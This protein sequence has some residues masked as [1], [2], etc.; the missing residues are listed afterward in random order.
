ML[1]T[2]SDNGDNA[3][4]PYH[5]EDVF[6]VTNPKMPNAVREHRVTAAAP[7]CT[8][9]RKNIPRAS[10]GNRCDGNNSAHG[11]ENSSSREGAKDSSTCREEVVEAAGEEEY[12]DELIV[13]NPIH[14]VGELR[15]LAQDLRTWKQHIDMVVDRSVKRVSNG[16][17]DKPSNKCT[18][19]EEENEDMSQRRHA[20]HIE[21][22][23]SED[24]NS[25]VFSGSHSPSSVIEDGN[26]AHIGNCCDE[27]S[28]SDDGTSIKFQ[29]VQVETAS[30]GD[31]ISHEGGVEVISANSEMEM[32]EKEILLQHEERNMA[33]EQGSVVTSTQDHPE[34]LE[35]ANTRNPTA[36]V[37]SRD[38]V[39]KAQESE[40]IDKEQQVSDA[41]DTS[42]IAGSH[43]SGSTCVS[44]LEVD[45]STNTCQ[46]G[47][48]S[49]S[50]REREQ[51]E[52][53]TMAE[54]HEETDVSDTI[55]AQNLQDIPHS[56]ELEQ[57]QQVDEEN[58]PE[59]NLPLGND[60]CQIDMT[61]GTDWAEDELHL[62]STSEDMDHVQS[63]CNEE[64]VIGKGCTIGSMADT[65]SRSEPSSNCSQRSGQVI[66]ETYNDIQENEVEGIRLESAS[67]DSTNLEEKRASYLHVAEMI[68]IEHTIEQH[69]GIST[70]ETTLNVEIQDPL[71]QTEVILTDS[72]EEED[73]IDQT[74]SVAHDEITNCS[75]IGH[76]KYLD[77]PRE[78]QQFHCENHSKPMEDLHFV[79]D[80]NRDI[81]LQTTKRIQLTEMDD[82]QNHAQDGCYGMCV[83]DYST[84]V[85][86]AAIS[87]E[88]EEA[89]TIIQTNVLKDISCITDALEMQES[90][91]QENEVECTI[92]P[93][94]THIEEK[95]SRCDMVNQKECNLSQ[96]AA[97]ED[98]ADGSIQSASTVQCDQNSIDDISLQIVKQN[99]F[100]EFE[101]QEHIHS[102]ISLGSI[103]D[104]NQH[105]SHS[106][107]EMQCETDIPNSDSEPEIVSTEKNEEERQNI[108]E[109][110]EAVNSDLQQS[111]NVS[112]CAALEVLEVDPITT[113]TV[114]QD[115]NDLEIPES[116]IPQDPEDTLIDQ[117]TITSAF[118]GITIATAGSLSIPQ[119]Q[120]RDLIAKHGGKWVK[121]ASRVC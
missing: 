13:F 4:D 1:N 87:E 90:E 52:D 11:I 121:N 56:N 110:L 21:F 96:I 116:H 3:E 70:I 27:L 85:Q 60:Q 84:S 77:I 26:S 118:Q 120:I 40:T 89:S 111:S 61:D 12:K 101:S 25:P 15:E 62:S 58:R 80:V 47:I 42:F 72:H 100:I 99:S 8:N 32:L 31:E 117:E 107:E 108:I 17:N 94:D 50:S 37:A 98:D 75:A 6:I 53:E 95:P 67:A 22:S 109:D 64:T 38:E 7:V 10:H 14:V 66:A 76:A 55:I 82:N 30:C 9:G 43:I 93:M 18:Q 29:S 92:C 39:L 20:H 73:I 5:D 23:K 41:T 97:T 36:H 78:G 35:G 24:D 34:R 63:N 59:E 68:A 57:E 48:T 74:E 69:G 19:E 88:H 46:D 106:H 103:H 33:S 54:T 113:T 104:D 16:I 102:N 91:H 44:K 79:D 115:Q 65:S 114:S 51:K 83:I 119:S 49:E 45:T 105:V 71:T 86:H 2:K 112:A 28:L 81:Q